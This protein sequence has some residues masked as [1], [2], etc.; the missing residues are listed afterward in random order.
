MRGNIVRSWTDKPWY[1]KDLLQE[2]QGP[3]LLSLL[4]VFSMAEEDKPQLFFSRK[5]SLRTGNCEGVHY[6]HRLGWFEPVCDSFADLCSAPWTASLSGSDL[7]VW[8]HKS[9]C[10]NASEAVPIQ[11]HG[12][13]TI[14]GC[15]LE[16]SQPGP[17]PG[18]PEPSVPLCLIH[19][20]RIF[21]NNVKQHKKETAPA[22]TATL[23]Q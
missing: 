13:K 19:H 7:S 18:H 9:F 4:P 23:S 10:L 21:N 1:E 17:L 6:E 22:S 14:Q 16:I 12:F 5:A 20:P 3:S 2:M 15:S 8:T 11:S